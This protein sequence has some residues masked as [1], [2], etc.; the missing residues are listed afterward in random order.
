MVQGLC[1]AR[2]GKSLCPQPHVVDQIWRVVSRCT[3]L[4]ILPH[5]KLQMPGVSCPGT[6]KNAGSL[7]LSSPPPIPWRLLGCSACRPSTQGRRESQNQKTARIW[8]RRRMTRRRQT[9]LRNPLL[10]SRPSRSEPPTEVG[11]SLKPLR[12]KVSRCAMAQMCLTSGHALEGNTPIRRAHGR[13][14][15]LPDQQTQ[16]SIV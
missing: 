8:S 4:P 7:T 13:P 1:H 3:V 15:G 2:K 6:Q 12:G 10:N 5:A 11:V 9:R 14:P 16:G